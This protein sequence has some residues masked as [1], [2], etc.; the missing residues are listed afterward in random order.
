M[1]VVIVMKVYSIKLA[2]VVKI[3]Q[4]VL[5]GMI[6]QAQNAVGATS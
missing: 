4:L 5:G 2:H 3:P 1:I 6:K